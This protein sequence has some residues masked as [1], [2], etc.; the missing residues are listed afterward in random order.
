MPPTTRRVPTDRKKKT[1]KVSPVVSDV[2]IETVEGDAKYAATGWGSSIGGAE[3]LLMPSG[4]LALVKRPGVEGMIKAGVLNDMDTLTG[5]VETTHLSKGKQIDV[6]S[7]AADA[8][9]IEN[10]LHVVDRV[11]CHV[12]MK[13]AVFP[14]PNDIT[15]RKDGVIYADMID[16]NDK[17]FI[18]NYAVGGTKD[19]EQFRKESEAAMGSVDAQ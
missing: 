4:Q 11:V 14:T 15:S 9:N 10:I 18:F 7:L 2:R 6:K 1:E 12:V 3:D 8:T 5:L 13:P 16:I 17:M 19:F